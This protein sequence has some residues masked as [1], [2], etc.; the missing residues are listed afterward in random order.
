MFQGI[1]MR[2]AKPELVSGKESGQKQR[3]RYAAPDKTERLSKTETPVSFHNCHSRGL[4]F[5]WLVR[6]T[7]TSATI[8]R[9]PTGDPFCCCYSAR[10]AFRW[11][12]ALVFS[13]SYSLQQAFMRREQR[14]GTVKD[15]VDDLLFRLRAL[16]TRIN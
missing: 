9:G 6:G 1:A 15:F 8:L 14:Y 7:V 11:P 3:A 13:Y 5:C 2:D 10:G 16:K 4:T 12:P